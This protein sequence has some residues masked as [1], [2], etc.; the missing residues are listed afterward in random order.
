MVSK[1]LDTKEN[2]EGKF[3]ERARNELLFYEIYWELGY[4]NLSRKTIGYFPN[5]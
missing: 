5:N 4:K 1:S 2:V 3:G